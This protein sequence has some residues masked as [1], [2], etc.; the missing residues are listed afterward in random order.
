MFWKATRLPS[1]N[2]NFC[3][4][5]FV[6]FAYVIYECLVACGLIWKSNF[7]QTNMLGAISGQ[8]ELY[9]LF[10]PAVLWW[11]HVDAFVQRLLIVKNILLHYFVSRHILSA[12]SLREG[13]KVL[14]L[15]VSFDYKLSRLI[16]FW[17]FPRLLVSL[18]SVTSVLA[19]FY[20]IFA[21]NWH[22]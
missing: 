15:L 4:C 21:I 1:G 11:P 6:T 10:L 19:S 16:S 14:I 13:K 18:L 7:L 8:S 20:S 5:N 9:I 17:R 3:Y 2:P 22:H 12:S